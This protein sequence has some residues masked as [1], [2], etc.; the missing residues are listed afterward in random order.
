MLKEVTELF[1]G[2]KQPP[3]L[4][5]LET[6]NLWDMLQTRYGTV[7]Q[8]KLFQ[9]YVHDKDFKFLL[10]QNILKLFQKQINELETLMETYQISM[11]RRPPNSVRTPT[12]AE[13]FTDHFIASTMMTRL[14]EN[15]GL[16]I[17]A[18]RTSITNDSIRA[19][20]Q[21]YLFTEL[22]L[23][24]S[25]VKYLKLKG[26]IGMPPLYPQTPPGTQERLDTGEA[27][28]LWDHLSA[29]YDSLEI[30]QIYENFTHDRDFAYFLR[31]GI[32]S[33]LEKQINIL[34]KEM[35]RFGLPLPERPPKSIK[36]VQ[37]IEV[38]K[39][40]IIYR[41]ILTGMQYMFELHATAIKQNSTNDRLRKIY[42]DFLKEEID[43]YNN[44][45]KYGKLKGW[46]RLV[47]MYRPA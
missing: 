2:K 10:T 7:E 23:Y 46:V 1:F 6:Y 20:F 14:Q 9:N 32:R 35:D 24:D 31:S 15:I 28:H 33:T 47:P 22:D 13:A 3:P 37:N 4:D 18:I 39:D 16:H 5:N 30:T 40:L 21:S 8:V 42:Q 27:Y 11:P 41:Q 36:K 29:R 38:L 17:R 34:E 19:L 43:I 25:A 12:N 45:L 26:W 44:F